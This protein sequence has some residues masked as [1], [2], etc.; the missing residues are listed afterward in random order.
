MRR[1]PVAI[2]TA[3]ANE[4]HY[5]VD[6]AFFGL[7]LGPRRKY[8]GCLWPAGVETLEAAE[9]AMLELTCRRAGIEDG[10][11]ILD[12]G[13]GWGSLSGFL[14]ERYPADAGARSVELGAPA[15]P[16]RVARARRTSRS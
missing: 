5:E 4:Q 15:R 3:D 14:A 12:L 8:S 9:V 10:M 7:V 11:E 1:S 13:C 16:H 2:E 6:P